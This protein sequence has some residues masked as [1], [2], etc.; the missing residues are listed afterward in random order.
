MNTWKPS[1]RDWVTSPPPEPWKASV[2]FLNTV[3]FCDT[4][5]KEFATCV[6]KPIFGNG[7][8]LDNVIECDAYS[9]KI[10]AKQ[11]CICGYGG[12]LNRFSKT[13]AACRKFL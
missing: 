8:G 6:S 7:K 9:Q 1:V 2:P 5:D 4:C 13:C 11:C 3:H 12:E 10:L